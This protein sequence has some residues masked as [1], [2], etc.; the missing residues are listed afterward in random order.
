MRLRQILIEPTAHTP[1]DLKEIIGV[2]PPHKKVRPP[3][4][5]VVEVRLQFGRSMDAQRIRQ[6]VI[7]IYLILLDSKLA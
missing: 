1:R 7:P 4:L 2:H 3:T 5:D 6:R